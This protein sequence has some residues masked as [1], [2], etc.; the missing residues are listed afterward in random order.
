M[1][2]DKKTQLVHAEVEPTVTTQTLKL[3]QLQ[4][5]KKI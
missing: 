4:T 2:K 1:S 3:K 5:Q